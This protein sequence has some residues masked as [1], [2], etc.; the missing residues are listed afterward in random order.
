MTLNFVFELGKYF[1]PGTFHFPIK[2]LSI[3]SFQKRSSLQI[4]MLCITSLSLTDAILIAAVM[5]CHSPG[6]GTFFGDVDLRSISSSRQC[7]SMRRQTLNTGQ[8]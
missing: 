3:S 5:N 6:S 2:T 8:R 7:R 4:P 1:L